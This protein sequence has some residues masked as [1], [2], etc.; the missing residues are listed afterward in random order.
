MTVSALIMRIYLFPEDWK[1][2]TLAY[3]S[4]LVSVKPQT[5]DNAIAVKAPPDTEF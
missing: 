1:D 5:E 2:K 3:Y 4:R